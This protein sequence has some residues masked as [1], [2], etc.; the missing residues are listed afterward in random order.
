MASKNRSWRM[1]G[2]V[3]MSLADLHRYIDFSVYAP[4]DPSLTRQ[5]METICAKIRAAAIP[6]TAESH[7]RHVEFV[8]SVKE[9]APR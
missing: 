3:C 5:T 8:Q 4:S 9:E 2:V 1:R 7:V 6:V